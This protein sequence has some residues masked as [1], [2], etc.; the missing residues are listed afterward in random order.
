VTRPAGSGDR[1]RKRWRGWPRRRRGFLI[2]SSRKQFGF[3]KL[4]VVRGCV[5]ERIIKA[6][7][8]PFRGVY[9][10]VEI[11]LDIDR[12]EDQ[13]FVTNLPRHRMETID[14]DSIFAIKA[15]IGP[16]TDGS[17]VEQP[18]PFHA[19][20]KRLFLDLVRSPHGHGIFV[21]NRKLQRL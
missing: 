13:A 9:K 14:R 7:A 12:V 16:I 10:S 20:I 11:F 15:V 6:T 21:V 17:S 5:R 19:K 8:I 3:K 4:L 18:L 2:F 1:L